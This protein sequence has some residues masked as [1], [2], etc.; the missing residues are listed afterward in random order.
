MPFDSREIADATS[1]IHQSYQTIPHLRN[2]PRTLLVFPFFK[3]PRGR[4]F[5]AVQEWTVKPHV[6][7]T[8][9]QGVHFDPPRGKS[10]RRALNH[11]GLS[12]DLGLDDR[13]T[14]RE[15]MVG[16]LGRYVRPQKISE[17]V[18]GKLLAGI[19]REPNQKSEVLART[20]SNLLA[21]NGEQ[22]GTTEAVQQKMVSHPR[23]RVLM[24]RYRDKA[25]E[26][27]RCQHLELYDFGVGLGSVLKWTSNARRA[28]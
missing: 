24:I 4:D 16:E 10:N 5:E 28:G 25:C 14:L 19:E 17:V 7:I 20:K 3:R 8:Q 21:G 1:G 23:A 12:R 2:Q 9:V 15:R 6:P 11:D 18:A 26:S 13:Q 22:G 27:K